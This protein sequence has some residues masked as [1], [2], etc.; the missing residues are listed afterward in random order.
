LQ[1]NTLAEVIMFVTDTS[2][3]A[4]HNKDD[5]FMNVFNLVLLQYLNASMP[6]G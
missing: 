5:N 2:I 3:L 1:I 4:S 6:I